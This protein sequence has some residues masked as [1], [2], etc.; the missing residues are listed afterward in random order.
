MALG[1][2]DNDTPDTPTPDVPRL[3]KTLEHITAH[4]DEW[5]Q[6]FWAVDWEMYR[7][8]WCG[9]GPV[10]KR[11]LA[12][13]MGRP[14]CGTAYCVA[15]RTVVDAG[16]QIVMK[17]DGGAYQ[18]IDPGRHA[19][20]APDVCNISHKARELL[21]LTR[22]EAIALFEETNTLNDLWRIGQRIAARAG[23]VL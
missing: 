17:A 11:R 4:P 23:E 1:W 19:S 6:S 9:D 2:T 7:E 16:C 5:D 12:M 3:R 8:Y 13:T 18:C 20:S 22:D 15:G 14:A 10:L 21:G